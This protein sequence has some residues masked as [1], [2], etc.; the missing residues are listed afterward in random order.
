MTKADLDRMMKLL[1]GDRE[2][3]III[4]KEIFKENKITED[5]KIILDNKLLQ[6]LF[7]IKKVSDENNE[8][9]Y[10]TFDLNEDMIYLYERIDFSQFTYDKLLIWC[11]RDLDLM[12]QYNITLYTDRLFRKDLS[13]V[14]LKGVRVVGNFDGFVVKEMD[15]TGIIGGELSPKKVYEK[16]LTGAILCDIYI[17]SDLD[18]CIIK[19]TNFKGVKGSVVLHPQKVRD[20]NLS[21][22]TLADVYIDG[23]LDGCDI[24]YT[25]FSDYK[26]VVELNPQNIKDKKMIATKLSG[27]NINGSFDGCYIYSVNFKGSKGAKID[28]KKINID[29]EWGLNCNFADAKIYNW[30]D[31]I[32]LDH[33]TV[34]WQREYDRSKFDKAN[35]IYNI[36]TKNKVNKYKNLP[37]LASANFVNEDEKLENDIRNVFSKEICNSQEKKLV[38]KK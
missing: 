9:V 25:N 36:L 18:D 24:T 17:D 4:L 5:N 32:I 28:L 34:K 8:E 12:A 2:K 27:V 26:G 1:K 21:G 29:A 31:G 6:E 30:E 37:Q 23:S 14:K 33:E 19:C 22:A 38:L 3:F 13:G 7:L 10:Y 20:K 11:Q 35:L 16:D 15:F